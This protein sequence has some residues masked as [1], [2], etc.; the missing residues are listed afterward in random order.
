MGTRSNTRKKAEGR[1][2]QSEPWPSCHAFQIDCVLLGFEKQF[3]LRSKWV[4]QRRNPL[5]WVTVV[6]AR[7]VVRPPV[8]QPAPQYLFLWQKDS[9]APVRIFRPVG[10]RRGVDFGL[11]RSSRHWMVSGSSKLS[12]RGRGRDGMGVTLVS[13][14]WGEASRLTLGWLGHWVHLAPILSGHILLC[15]RWRWGWVADGRVSDL[16]FVLTPGNSPRR[17]SSSIIVGSNAKA[18]HFGNLFAS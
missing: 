6:T 2:C 10:A 4:R 8:L 1:E 14:S 9:G 13:R 17:D 7:R 15:W 16:G 11:F 5:V 12:Y 3:I 18:L